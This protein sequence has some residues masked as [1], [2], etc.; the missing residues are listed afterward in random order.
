MTAVTVITTEQAP[1]AK[2]KATSI[3]LDTSWQTLIDVPVY[4]VPV[5]GF[6]SSRRIAPGVCEP[7]SPIL[8]TNVS[9]SNVAKVDVRVIRSERPLEAGLTEANFVGTFS[10]GQD[11]GVGN[12]VVMNN[13]ASITVGNVDANGS[14]TEFTITTGGDPVVPEIALTQSFISG[15]G[16]PGEGFTITP[17]REDLSEA[18]GVL[19]LARNLQVEVDDVLIIPINGQFFLS[20]DILE[21]RSDTNDALHA[22]LS[23][24]EG[25][26]EEN[27]V[28]L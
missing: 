22:T 19:Y 18:T 23:F 28:S 24:T 15:L 16:G 10:A 27:D 1:S 7:S 9:E 4:N 13:N 26:A 6:G 21:I 8:V 14:I 11:Y 17:D 25:Q 3:V 2:P 5:I 20:R 12:V